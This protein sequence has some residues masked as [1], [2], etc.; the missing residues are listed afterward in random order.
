MLCPAWDHLGQLKFPPNARIQSAYFFGDVK[1][2]AESLSKS[3]TSSNVSQE[4]VYSINDQKKVTIRNFH[5]YR[6]AQVINV[7]K[8][9]IK[10][11]NPSKFSFAREGVICKVGDQ[12]VK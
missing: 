7:L 9:T 5:G 2:S 10:C 11:Q 3:N 4:I 8:D 1:K 12:A 6:W